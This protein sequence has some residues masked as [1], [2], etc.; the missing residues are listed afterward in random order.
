MGRAEKLEMSVGT[1]L[2]VVGTATEEEAEALGL[3]MVNLGEALPESPK[4]TNKE[5][6]LGLHRDGT[7]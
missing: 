2:T 1:E 4:T 7:L 5:G 6:E 3:S